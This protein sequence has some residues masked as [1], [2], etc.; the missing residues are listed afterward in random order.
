MHK[1][2][3]YFINKFEKKTINNLDKNIDIIY[4]NYSKKYSTKEIIEIK[5]ICRLKNR[6]FFLANNHKLALNLNLDGVY[7][8]SF[9]KK[10]IPYISRKKK[11]YILGS[12]HNLKEISEKRR[13]GV[14]YL[15]LSPLFK[16][17][18]KNYFLGPSKYNIL[19]SHFHKKTIALGGINN[20]NINFIDKINCYG[21]A[22]ISYIENHK[23]NE[24]RNIT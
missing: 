18:K 1:K 5:K 9:N 4:R 2:S 13:Q 21:F 22:S 6:K 10:P 12:A 8:P 23:I 19:A 15:F 11:F 3:F 14:D 17:E 7:I 24:Q 16:I 20:K